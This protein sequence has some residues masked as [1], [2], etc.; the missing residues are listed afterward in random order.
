[1]TIWDKS[2][3]CT[4][5]VQGQQ[6]SS[7]LSPVG[8]PSPCTVPASIYSPPGSAHAH[9]HAFPELTSS[10][11]PSLSFPFFLLLPQWGCTTCWCLTKNRVCGVARWERRAET[12]KGQP[13][14]YQCCEA[15]VGCDATAPLWVHEQ[16]ASMQQREDC[17]VPV[18]CCKHA[19]EGCPHWLVSLVKVPLRLLQAG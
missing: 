7:Q 19:A 10:P 17:G 11:S 13:H 18:L 12:L 6:G 3:R 16:T 2:P 14:A 4:S 9:L 1:M 15:G 8:S 5:R